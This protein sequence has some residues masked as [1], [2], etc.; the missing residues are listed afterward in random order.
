MTAKR[1]IRPV[2]AQ[3]IV[4]VPEG[5]VIVDG[6]LDYITDEATPTP[7]DAIYAASMDA[8]GKV[9]VDKDE[10][11]DLAAHTFAGWPTPKGA[12]ALAV[13]EVA[14]EAK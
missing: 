1:I 2:P 4:A 8:A 10:T 9:D 11:A 14:E 6:H 13:D 3:G 5:A 12:R 7:G